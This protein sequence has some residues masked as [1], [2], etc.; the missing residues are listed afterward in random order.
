MSVT[1]A[2]PSMSTPKARN[3]TVATLLMASTIA[4][5]TAIS[6]YFW[7]ELGTPILVGLTAI[8]VGLTTVIVRRT[9]P[10]SAKC[11]SAVNRTVNDGGLREIDSAPTS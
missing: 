2:R 11:P 1:E 4:V 8:V 5:G 3:V 10:V 9:G 6:V 7:P